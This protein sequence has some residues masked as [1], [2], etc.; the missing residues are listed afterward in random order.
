[1]PVLVEASAWW[2]GAVGVWIA[3][4]SAWSM[5]DFVVA[6][7]CAVPC[8]AAAVAARRAMRDS[9]RPPAESLRWLAV[10]PWSVL[11][12]SVRVL[13][14]PF[15]SIGAGRSSTTGQLRTVN[16][17]ARGESAQAAG[18]HAV[19]IA[20]L[21]STPGTYVVSVDAKAGTALI[22]AIGDRPSAVERACAR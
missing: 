1:V 2:C 7:G 22:H 18:R 5:H 19:A 9:W 17:G 15:R 10:V 3:S 16:V 20:V 11:A 14:L 13:T 21:S 12:D 8:A 4:L 6:A